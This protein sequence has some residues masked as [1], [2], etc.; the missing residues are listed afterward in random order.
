MKTNVLLFLLCVLALP[1]IPVDPQ[2]AFSQEE[3]PVPVEFGEILKTPQ[4]GLIESVQT[5]MVKVYGASGFVGITAW[6]TGFLVSTDGQIVTSF[7]AAIDTQDLQVVLNDG[8]RYTAKLKNADPVT[9]VALLQIVKPQPLND[10]ADKAKGNQTSKADKANNSNNKNEKGQPDAGDPEAA[11]EFK[12]PSWDLPEQAKLQQRTHN[13]SM[14]GTPIYSV[15]NEFGMATGNEPCAVDAGIISV[16][17]DLAQASASFAYR[18]RSKIYLLDAVTSNPCQP[19][20]AVI[21]ARDGRLLG[22][23]AKS[24]VDPGTGRTLY[25]V[26]PIEALDKCVKTLQEGEITISRDRSA[27]AKAWS[28]ERLGLALFPRIV[29][30]TPAYVESVVP[31]LEAEKIGIQA[32][33]LIL[34]VNGR[35]VQSVDDVRTELAFTDQADP[36]SITVERNNEILELPVKAEPEEGEKK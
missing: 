26:L 28:E 24:A 25:C 17:L 7:T 1:V 36:I 8:S 13:R 19:G 10:D 21:H 20:G 12:T 15:T 32:N 23:V 9:E 22:M 35:L 31:G 30:K 5:R 18:Y 11:P 33:D 2:T 3:D 34:Y 6:Q 4:R 14:A 16:E 29:D 27:P